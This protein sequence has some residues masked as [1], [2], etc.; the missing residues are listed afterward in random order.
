MASDIKGM[1]NILNS[2]TWAYI[3]VP[4]NSDFYD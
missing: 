4:L 2:K 1:E 3:A